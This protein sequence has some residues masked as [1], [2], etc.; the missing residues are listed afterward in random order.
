VLGSRVFSGVLY[1]LHATDPIA[2]GG[3]SLVLLVAATIAV[4]VPTRRAAA[5]DPAA[6]LR[7][8]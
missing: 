7:Q 1:G 3:A 5:I 6:T 4:F 8:L 2:F